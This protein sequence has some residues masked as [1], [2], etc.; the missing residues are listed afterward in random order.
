MMALQKMLETSWEE[1]GRVHGDFVKT[2]C[3]TVNCGCV[4]FRTSAGTQAELLVP[5]LLLESS[6]VFAAF[7]P[8]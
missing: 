1:K 2:S 8:C 6:P 7:F 5:L 3:E 4:S